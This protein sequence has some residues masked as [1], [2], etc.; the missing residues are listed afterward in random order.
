MKVV[1]T[2]AIV[3]DDDELAQVVDEFVRQDPD[4]GDRKKE[5][6]DLE[7]E[8]RVYY[9]DADSWQEHVR[10]AELRD[11]RHADILVA[12]SKWAFNEGR[13]SPRDSSGTPRRTVG[14]VPV[15]RVGQGDDA[16][17]VEDAQDP[18]DMDGIDGTG[19]RC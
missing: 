14:L 16:Q 9:A 3:E 4:A 5:I 10:L 8:F 7:E 15:K 2:P 1:L 19:D 18:A 17:A 13:R 6:D 12:V 11:K